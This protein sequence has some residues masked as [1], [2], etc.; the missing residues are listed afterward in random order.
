MAKNQRKKTFR[1][2]VPVAF[3]LSLL[4]A[5]LGV[6]AP[7]TSARVQNNS[8]ID[9]RAF[10]VVP[11]AHNSESAKQP[12]RISAQIERIR[13]NLN[14]VVAKSGGS[15]EVPGVALGLYHDGE[16]VTTSSNGIGLT[17]QVPI[18]STSKIFTGFA[19]VRLA[20]QGR[21]DLDAPVSEYLPEF[22]KAEFDSK[23]PLTI[24]ELLQHR[25]GISYKGGKRIIVAG[26]SVPVPK[27]APGT[28]FEYSNHNYELAGAVISRIQG[29]PFAEA[30]KELV[31]LPL[32]LENT[33]VAGYGKG[34]SGIHTTVHDMN[35]LGNYLLKDYR[36]NR[37]TSYLAEMAG[38]PDHLKAAADM[39]YYGLGIR[40]AIRKG[41]LYNMF[42]IGQWY[43]S[44]AYLGLY[45][46]SQ[47]SSAFVTNPPQFR[48]EKA[49]HVLESLIS[50]S[51]QMADAVNR[52][53][54]L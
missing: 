31:F 15:A 54:S 45:P 29:K 32:N 49:K 26:F 25:S 28:V 23:N 39:D 12:L 11:A 22:K 3:S 21:V 30:M 19:M 1:K 43:N 16:P 38:R 41:V 36:E 27:S 50:G 17:Q 53:V 5:A 18:A 51:A 24:R 42:H 9:N 8:E 35:E 13:S 4:S 46:E 40:V 2:R 52:A 37:E 34:A 48:S 33:I 20:R 6:S 10:A 7:G 44:V 14:A 47:V